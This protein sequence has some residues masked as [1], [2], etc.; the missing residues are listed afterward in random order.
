MLRAKLKLIG[1]G[2]AAVDREAYLYEDIRIGEVVGWIFNNE[3][4]GYRLK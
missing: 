4:R 3:M 1:R 2:S